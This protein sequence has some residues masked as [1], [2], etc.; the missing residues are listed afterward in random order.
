MTRP[1]TMFICG[2]DEAVLG[3]AHRCGQPAIVVYDHDKLVEKFVRDGMTADEAEEWVSYNIE[4]AWMGEGTPAVLRRKT[5][6]EITD[7]AAA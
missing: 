2:C 5:V 1:E 4:G 3:L 6:D 7:E